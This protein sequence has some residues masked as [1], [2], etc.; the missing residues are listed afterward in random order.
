MVRIAAIGD[1]HIRGDIP[2]VLGLLA[3][4]SLVIHSSQQ[5]AFEPTAALYRLA[6]ADF[7]LLPL[8]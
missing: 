5:N 7:K 6:R 4:R 3:P 8:P 2:E 1:F